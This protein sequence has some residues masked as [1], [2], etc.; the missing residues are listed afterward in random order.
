[1]GSIYHVEKNDLLLFNVSRI[2]ERARAPLVFVFVFAFCFVTFRGRLVFPMFEPGGTTITKNIKEEEE[3]EIEKLVLLPFFVCFI[4]LFEFFPL[5]HEARKQWSGFE[6]FSFIVR[7][8]FFLCSSSSSCVISLSCRPP[9]RSMSGCVNP[10]REIFVLVAQ[11]EPT[12]SVVIAAPNF[13]DAL[14]GLEE[15]RPLILSRYITPFECPAG[16][17]SSRKRRGHKKESVTLFQISIATG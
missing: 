7:V 10:P 2:L 3:E 13:H 5:L 6:R 4:I 16:L 8:L 1:M 9:T 17:D 12:S 14:R 11:N 15:G